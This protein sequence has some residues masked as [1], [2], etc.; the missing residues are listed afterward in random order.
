MPGHEVTPV[1]TGDVCLNYDI[2]WFADRK[3]APP[4]TLDD[5]TSPTYKNL[6]VVENPASSSP[7]LAFLLG[8]VAKYGETSWVEYWTQLKANG[9][10]AVDSWDAAYFEEF[11]QGGGAGTHPLVVSY[12]SSPPYALVAGDEPRPT[13]PTTASIDTTC[14][15][16]VEFAGVLTGAKHPAEAKQLIDFLIGDEFQSQLPVT[17][18][19]Y[20]V[21]SGVALPD[22]FVKFG[23]PT[24]DPLTIAPDVIAA[25]R[26]GWIESWTKAVIG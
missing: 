2:A 3:L 18:F 22:A 10:L 8:T 16:Q 26:D 20:P 19:V 14:F 9:V 15:R 25:K 17:N 1:D 4:A 23:A 11:T 24:A 21:R 5:L 12:A 7:G 6:L 13:E